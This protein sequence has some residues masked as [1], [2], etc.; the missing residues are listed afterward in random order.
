MAGALANF[1]LHSKFI[2][3]I[4][5]SFV[6]NNQHRRRPYDIVVSATG[7]EPDL[8]I[9]APSSR[10]EMHGGFSLPRITHEYESINVPGLYFAGAISHAKDKRRSSGGFIHGF[11][12]NTRALFRILEEKYHESEW[13]N[14]HFNVA[15]SSGIDALVDK[16]LSRINHASG[17]Y[18][19]FY[20]L[21][22]AVVFSP[23]PED[24]VSEAKYYEDMPVDYFVQNFRKRDKM[25]IMF[26][27][28]GQR[29]SISE[30]LWHGTG[31]EP[32]LWFLP[33]HEDGQ[34]SSRKWLQ[35][36]ESVHTGAR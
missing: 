35:L 33:A 16:I 5:N 21:G 18:Q 13:P 32:W 22:D 25:M 6:L 17:P 36:M 11:R 1:S 27:F 30:S 2:F 9:Y 14:Q 19:M 29:R 8:G 4:R 24:S 7:W 23:L 12:Y 15:L 20:A 3:C 34:L 26:G 10:P 31:F 28:D